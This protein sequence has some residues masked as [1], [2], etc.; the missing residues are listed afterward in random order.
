MVTSQVIDIKAKNVACVRTLLTVA[1]TDGNYL[2]EAWYDVS[3]GLELHANVETT[4]RSFQIIKCI[5]QLELAQLF[6]VH[7]VKGK[8]TLSNPNTNAHFHLDKGPT[9]P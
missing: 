3:V 2:G 7:T 9:A 6:S 4:R 1:Q 5:S 8:L